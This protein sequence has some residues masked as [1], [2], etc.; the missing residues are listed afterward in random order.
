MARP[1]CGLYSEPMQKRLLTEAD[2]TFKKACKIAQAM[3]LADQNVGY[4]LSS[5]FELYQQD[6]G[7]CKTPQNDSEMEN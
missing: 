4:S 7:L 2:L 5:I 1:L 6:S 3:E